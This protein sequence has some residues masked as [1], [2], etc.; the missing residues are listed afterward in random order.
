LHLHR[1]QTTI[2]NTN[3]SLGADASCLL[4][5]RSVALSIQKTLISTLFRVLDSSHTT[6][7][8]FFQRSCT[9]QQRYYLY[10]LFL[11]HME[12]FLISSVFCIDNA[13]LLLR[14]RQLASAPNEQLVLG[15][16]VCGLCK[17][18]IFKLYPLYLLFPVAI[19]ISAQIG[20]F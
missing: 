19:K 10:V 1:P 20:Q 15:I 4:R 8:C 17:C 18:K 5:K 3:C 12:V 2:P 9:L 14:K 7:T 13:T 16:V 6:S 11:Y